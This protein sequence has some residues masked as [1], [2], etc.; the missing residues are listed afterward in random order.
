M[1]GYIARRIYSNVASIR[2]QRIHFKQFHDFDD[3][4]KKDSEKIELTQTM[5]T[6]IMLRTLIESYQSKVGFGIKD[7]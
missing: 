6:S 3:L 1:K 4:L 7:I 2:N 5:P